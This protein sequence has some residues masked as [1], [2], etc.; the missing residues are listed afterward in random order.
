M[1]VDDV[2]RELDGTVPDNGTGWRRSS[3]CDSRSESKKY[4]T[5]LDFELDCAQKILQE[6]Q[7]IDWMDESL[8]E[9][10]G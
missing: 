2:R 4:A 9:I 3:C 1:A 5:P 7:L 10:M 6:S 8:E